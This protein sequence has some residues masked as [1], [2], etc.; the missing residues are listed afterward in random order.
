MYLEDM[1]ECLLGHERQD[2]LA[3]VLLR[4][5]EL[6]HCLDHLILARDN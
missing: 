1:D 4:V 2:L 5:G 6:A 3:Q